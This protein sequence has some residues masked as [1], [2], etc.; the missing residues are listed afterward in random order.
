MVRLRWENLSEYDIERFRGGYAITGKC[1]WHQDREFDT[2]R[3]VKIYIENVLTSNVSSCNI[4][5]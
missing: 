2:I 3:F 4:K 5:I 1:G